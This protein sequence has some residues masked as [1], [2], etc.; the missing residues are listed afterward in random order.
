DARTQCALLPQDPYQTIPTANESSEAVFDTALLKEE[1]IVKTVL[2]PV[3]DLDFTGLYTQ[4]TVYR[5]SSNSAGAKHWFETKNFVLDFSVWLEN[6]R[7][8]K[9][10]YAGTTWSDDEYKVKINFVRQSLLPLQ[11]EQK[12]LSSGKYRAFISADA[13][14]EFATFFSWNGLGERGMRE[15]ESA[16]IPLREGRECFSEQ[17]T[18]SQD[19]SLGGEP[20][21]NTMGEVSDE[22]LV[23]IQNGKLVNTIINSR[24]AKEYG[25]TSNG[26]D[27]G[28]GVRSLCIAGGS[29]E[30]DKILEA[31]GTGI[32]V[33]NFHYL[34]WS[35]VQNARITG[36]T[37]FAC[38]WV[39]NGK[40][41]APISD[42]RWDDSLYN[43]FGAKLQAITSERHLFPETSTYERR[44][45]G[46]CLL[47]GILVSE[48]NCTL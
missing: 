19:F 38:L 17:F 36:M 26:A 24:T 47:P 37:R 31:L 14:H 15:G 7:A 30:E 21:F 45:V 41:V 5:G 48:L 11:N 23:L 16:F 1:D 10:S 2:D 6:G 22:K 3:S 40:I 34:N 43:L 42:M 25:L 28:E 13:L 29:L 39:E 32:Y 8:V 33:S 35:D 46:S 4:G 12:K 9:S 27:E 18:V 20:A 44:E